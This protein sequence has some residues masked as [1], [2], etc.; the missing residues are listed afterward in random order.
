[1]DNV[2]NRPLMMSLGVSRRPSGSTVKARLL[3]VKRTLAQQ[4]RLTR[5]YNVSEQNL[6]YKTGETGSAVLW[7]WCADQPQRPT[8]GRGPRTGHAQRPMNDGPRTYT[9]SRSALRWRPMG[10]WP[11]QFRAF[12]RLTD[13]LLAVPRERLDTRLAEYREQTAQKARRPGPKPTKV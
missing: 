3:L 2:H 13:K 11:K 7:P 9:D 12:V 10:R 4:G 8:E 5:Q 6:I 1:M